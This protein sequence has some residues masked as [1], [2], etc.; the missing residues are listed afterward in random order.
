NSPVTASGIESPASAPAKVLIPPPPEPEPAGEAAPAQ[1]SADAAQDPAPGA[2]KAEPGAA[3][4]PEG[5][6]PGTTNPVT[7]PPSDPKP[8]DAPNV[9]S[10]VTVGPRRDL[11][12]APIL[13]YSAQLPKVSSSETEE[14][15][16]EPVEAEGGQELAAPVTLPSSLRRPVV[17]KSLYVAGAALLLVTALHIARA[18]R[19]L[20]EVAEVE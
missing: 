14:L 5:S 18:A 16:P 6:Q 13:P 17:Q 11:G 19:R 2:A 4:K 20:G 12:F 3:A 7:L 1:A 15:A 10:P 8:I 9:V